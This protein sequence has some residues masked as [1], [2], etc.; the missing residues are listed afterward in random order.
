MNKP[1][2]TLTVNPAIDQT[3][4]VDG[5][6]IGAV[7]RVARAERHAGGKGINV[8]TVLAG[9]GERVTATGFLGRD[10]AAIFETHFQTHRIVDRMIRLP[11]E[12][13]TGIK[14]V[15]GSTRVVTD[16]NFPGLSPTPED[17]IALRTTIQQLITP[18][19]SIALGGSLPPGVPSTLYA[20]LVAKARQAGATV[21]VD[22]SG[23]AL[24]A[25]VAARPTIMKPNRAELEE[26]VGRSLLDLASVRAAA[27]D[28]VSE[29]IELVVVS[30]GGD[31]ALFV[32]AVEAIHAQPPPVEI[33]TTVGAG[34][35]LLAGVLHARSRDFSLE[36]IARLATAMGT[37]AVTKVG[38]GVA[39][40]DER[41]AMM[42][43]IQITRIN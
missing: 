12:T 42:E 18:D 6:A 43:R 15:D 25:A 31:G 7:N 38:A 11:G 28:I 5:F 13:R 3:V 27:Q 20:E 9:L 39:S 35:A 29:G 32:T 30:L 34:D 14:I 17:L 10:N 24:A 36:E 1:I 22:T 37:L 21:A 2:I 41:A 16:L 33:V 40:P 26:L 23:L 4:R 19:C 8:A